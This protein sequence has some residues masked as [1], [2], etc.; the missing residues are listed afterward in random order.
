M[1]KNPFGKHVIIQ[2]IQ[3]CDNCMKFVLVGSQW[4]MCCIENSNVRGPS[5]LNSVNMF[6]RRTILQEH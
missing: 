5:D 2:I 3:F 6:N 4:H 1:E